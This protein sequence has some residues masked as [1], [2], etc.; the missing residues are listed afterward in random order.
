MVDP[1]W[2]VNPLEAIS[3]SFSVLIFAPFEYIGG[4]IGLFL[5]GIIGGIPFWLQPLLIIIIFGLAFISIFGYRVVS[6]FLTLEPARREYLEHRPISPSNAITNEARQE[7]VERPERKVMK[8]IRNAATDMDGF[9]EFLKGRNEDRNIGG[10]QKVWWRKWTTPVTNFLWMIWNFLV[11]WIDVLLRQ[12]PT[13]SPS[14][15]NNEQDVPFQNDGNNDIVI[16]R[17]NTGRPVDD[18]DPPANR[19]IQ[20]I[21]VEEVFIP[22]RRMNVNLEKSSENKENDI[23]CDGNKTTERSS[24]PKP[25]SSSSSSSKLK[26]SPDTK[27]SESGAEL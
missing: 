27:H 1:F 3:R 24:D 15:P 6:P 18:A 25:C 23:V 12:V 22:R 11:H 16:P 21:N 17:R 9:E 19:P 4:K 8:S 7:L 2:S 14:A 5:G 26:T 13:S 10:D 20:Q